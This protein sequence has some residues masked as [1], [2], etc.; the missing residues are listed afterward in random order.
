MTARVVARLG[1][2][3]KRRVGERADRD[4]HEVR[5]RRLRVEDLRA[6]VGAEAEDGLLPV[7]LVRDARVVAEAADDLDLIRLERR[8]HPEGASRPTLAGEAVADGDR[9][10]LGRDLQTKLAA[11]TGRISGRHRGET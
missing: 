4:D 3:R 10:R 8:L 11:V 2:R 5:L 7:R 1:R 6:A 9:E